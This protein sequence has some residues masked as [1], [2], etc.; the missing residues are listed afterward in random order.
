MY[1]F[2][3]SLWIIWSSGLKN[4]KFN[5]DVNSERTVYI[6]QT[7]SE[8]RTW[9][10]GRGFLPLVLNHYYL[11]IAQSINR[12]T[13][14]LTVS[15]S[16]S[17]KSLMGK[18]EII[19]MQSKWESSHINLSQRGNEKGK[20]NITGNT[21][22]HPTFTFIKSIYIGEHIMSILLDPLYSIHFARFLSTTLYSVQNTCIVSCVLWH[23]LIHFHHF[24]TNIHS[25]FLS[26]W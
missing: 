25:Q 11:S 9:P 16:S 15:I 21:L 20:K 23:I 13:E 6:F 19:A 26:S 7:D 2:K 1:L 22:D 18:R 12:Y 17:A 5:F 24:A 14:W 4:P 10:I 8:R 3:L